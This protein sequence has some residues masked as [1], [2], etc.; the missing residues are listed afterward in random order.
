MT[1]RRALVP[2]FQVRTLRLRLAGA[3]AGLLRVLPMHCSRHGIAP[4]LTSAGA[5]SPGRA[6]RARMGALLLYRALS[7]ADAL[8]TC[9]P[10]TLAGVCWPA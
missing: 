1:R 4:K 5:G 2:S 6:G 7:G 3:V 10:L 9:S 8:S